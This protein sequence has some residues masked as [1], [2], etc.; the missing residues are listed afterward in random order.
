MVWL[1]VF[2]LSIDSAEGT[3]RY[4]FNLRLPCRM[5]LDYSGSEDRWVICIAL[6]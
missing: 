6:R 5:V 4:R 2:A 3:G 1:V